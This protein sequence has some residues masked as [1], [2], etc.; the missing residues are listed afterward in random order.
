MKAWVITDTET[1]SF[2]V[3]LCWIGVKVSQEV[4]EDCWFHG[5]SS[6][7]ALCQIDIDLPM[8]TLADFKYIFLLFALFA[9]V[10]IMPYCGL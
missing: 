3:V 4:D 9:V 10:W 7:S 5:R 8:I 6:E 2:D 1:L